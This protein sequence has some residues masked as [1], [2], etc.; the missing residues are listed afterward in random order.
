M[1]SD[2]IYSNS[3][4]SGTLTTWSYSCSFVCVCSVIQSCPTLCNL[5][6]CSSPGFSVH[7]ISQAR[8]LEWVAMPS[9]RW[10]LRPRN[11]TCVSC[12]SCIVAGFFTT[13]PLWKLPLSLEIMSSSQNRTRM[14]QRTL[15]Y[16]SRRDTIRVLPSLPIM[17][18]IGK[19]SI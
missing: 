8:I 16:P 3:R 14:V 10:H 11:W 1:W 2:R 4:L 6:D 7:R 17:F 15:M 13:E 18:F 5:M 12:V 9:S 19:G